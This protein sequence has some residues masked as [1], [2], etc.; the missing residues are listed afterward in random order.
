VD[1]I[2]CPPGAFCVDNQTISEPL[3]PSHAALPKGHNSTS[4]IIS[5]IF[6]GEAWNP[7]IRKSNEINKNGIFS[8]YVYLQQE[9]RISQFP[10]YTTEI[11][12]F[13]DGLN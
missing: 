2:G 8:G 13:P 5:R 1:I 10:L 6:I 9:T 3:N 7:G 12:Y 4:T 11:D